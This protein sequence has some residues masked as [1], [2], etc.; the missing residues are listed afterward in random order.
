MFVF[1][2]ISG[3]VLSYKYFTTNDRKIIISSA[4]KRY[5]RLTIPILFSCLIAYT[6]LHFNLFFN[7]KTSLLVNSAFLNNCYNFSPNF[8]KM[9]KFALY[10]VYFKYDTAGS[11]NPPLWIMPYEFFGSFLCFFLLL[12]IRSHRVRIIMYP[13]LFLLLFSFKGLFLN[14]TS[15]LLGMMLCDLNTA[16]N[17]KRLFLN[18][19]IILFIFFAMGIYF[20]SFKPYSV[21]L[22]GIL[23]KI[24][25]AP[26]VF[27]SNIVFYRYIGAFLVVC[28][29]THSKVLQ[30]IFSQKIL[31]F[32]GKISFMIY[33]LQVTVLCSL[34]SYIYYIFYSLVNSNKLCFI[35]TFVLSFPVIILLSWLSYMFVEKKSILASTKISDIMQ[36]SCRNIYY[37][38]KAKSSS[39]RLS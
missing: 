6:C 10:D 36:S 27:P 18:K 25:I 4:I 30:S 12:F 28:A 14:L 7:R 1:F 5:F 22:Y 26:L 34:S 9:I 3:Y 33:L 2:I 38:F 23:N 29:L 20:A 21:Y 31:L 8:F 19:K 24:S 11:Y 15:F 32:L 35:T 16:R 13:L 37:S 17:T 39:L